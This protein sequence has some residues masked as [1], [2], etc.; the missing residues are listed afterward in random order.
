MKQAHLRPSL[1]GSSSSLPL[2]AL[3]SMLE[4]AGST[5]I[6]RAAGAELRLAQG[7]LVRATGAATP[8]ATLAALMAAEAQPAGLAFTFRAT[9][10]RPN[11]ELSLPLSA[12]L[13]A[14]ATELDHTARDAKEVA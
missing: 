5:G 10:G 6:L 3:L 8:A 14:A 12:L 9:A 13:L 2:S 1:S 11:G 7:R 4:A